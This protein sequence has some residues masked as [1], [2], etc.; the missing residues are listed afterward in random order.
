M[1]LKWDSNPQLNVPQHSAPTVLATL[2]QLVVNPGL[3]VGGGGWGGGR[4]RSSSGRAQPYILPKFQ[5]RKNYFIGGR[6][7]TFKI[8]PK[9][10]F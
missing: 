1:N 10:N 5:N 3:T 9:V 6:F 2:A 4:G 7:A 8:N